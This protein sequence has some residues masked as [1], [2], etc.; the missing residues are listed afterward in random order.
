MSM[1]T[2]NM[3]SDL[4]SVFRRGEV[5]CGAL[6]RFACRMGGVGGAAA[7]R[8]REAGGALKV[9]YRIEYYESGGAVK[10]AL[11]PIVGWFAGF[12]QGG[13]QFEHLDEKYGVR[14]AI[15]VTLRRACIPRTWTF[16]GPAGRYKR[17]SGRRA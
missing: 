5:A 4:Q 9:L 16:C 13:A 7:V 17:S 10:Q 14:P 11:T 12:N 1:L 8:A 2:K 6:G 3:E 15:G